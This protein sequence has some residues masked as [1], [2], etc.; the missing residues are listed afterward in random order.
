MAIITINDIGAYMVGFF[1]GK[2]PLIKLSPKKTR[3]GFLGGGL[4][5]L[6]VGTVFTY[7]L[8]S[9]YLV[10]PIQV[11][12]DYL[13]QIVHNNYNGGTINMA[14]GGDS[15]LFSVSKCHPTVPFQPQIIQVIQ[16][17]CPALGIWVAFLKQPDALPGRAPQKI[18][19]I[20]I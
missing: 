16:M 9:P 11:N 10:C 1:A 5:T 19:I 17:G 4:I 13:V 8:I 15:P 6:V 3:E 2:T 20:Y 14:V 18:K 7:F 12:P